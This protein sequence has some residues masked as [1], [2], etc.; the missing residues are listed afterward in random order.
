MTRRNAGQPFEGHDR[1]VEQRRHADRRK[2]ERVNL[3]LKYLVV[4]I[5]VAVLMYILR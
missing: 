1:R 4:A 5:V 2:S 3:V